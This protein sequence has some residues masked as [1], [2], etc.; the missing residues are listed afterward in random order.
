M[1]HFKSV[2]VGNS[3]LLLLGCIIISFGVT[4]FYFK[5]TDSPKIENIIGHILL[6]PVYIVDGLV[7]LFGFNSVMSNPI[8]IFLVLLITYSII[9]F[10]A[11]K[12]FEWRHSEEQ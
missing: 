4:H 3:P 7:S 10:I 6:F 8:V 9:A 11:V 2:K 5:N 12:I 1:N